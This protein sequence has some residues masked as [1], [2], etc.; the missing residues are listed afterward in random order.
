MSDFSTCLTI[1][2]AVFF[3]PNMAEA[4]PA[5]LSAVSKGGG[6]SN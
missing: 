3:G 5:F 6:R 4:T 1:P 2:P